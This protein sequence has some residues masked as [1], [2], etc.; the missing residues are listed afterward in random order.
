[1]WPTTSGS[2]P[3]FSISCNDHSLSVFA[4]SFARTFAHSRPRWRS[5]FFRKRASNTRSSSSLCPAERS[6]LLSLLFFI[7]LVRRIMQ[8]EERVHAR[9]QLRLDGFLAALEHVH[10]AARLA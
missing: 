8:L 9:L 1:S 4:S 5:M 3:V 6:F 2:P 7:G 10:G